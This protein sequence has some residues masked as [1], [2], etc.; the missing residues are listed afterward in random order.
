MPNLKQ[1]THKTFYIDITIHKSYE[2]LTYN[3]NALLIFVVWEYGF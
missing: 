3:A 2:I 1:S